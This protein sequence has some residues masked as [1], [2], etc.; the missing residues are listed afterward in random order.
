MN[1]ANILHERIAAG[2]VSI[3]VRKSRGWSPWHQHGLCQRD[4]TIVTPRDKDAFLWV[5]KRCM[6]SQF[7]YELVGGGT[8]TSKPSGVDV[9][10]E[11]KCL[12]TLFIDEA[13]QELIVGAGVTVDSAEAF[14]A[15]RG[16]TLGQWLGSGATA[17]IGGSIVTNA[18]GILAGRYGTLRDAISSVEVVDAIGISTWASAADFRMMPSPTLLTVRI[19]LWLSPEGRALAR[20]VGAGDPFTA[21]RQVTTARLLPAHISVDQSG[22]ITVIAEGETHLETARYQ[23]IAAILQKHGAVQDLAL[24]QNRHWDTLISANPWSSNAGG[25]SWADRIFVQTTWEACA[26]VLDN[27]TQRAIR[28][29]AALTWNAVNPSHLGVW[30][31]IDINIPATTVEPEWLS[32]GN[33]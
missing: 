29:G 20:F 13:A 19:P 6:D 21:L 10:I 12:D 4:V 14:V 5:V 15:E 11:T 23:L 33:L 2:D 31:I 24:D 28:A 18:M 30:L 3:D 25:D 1:I 16:W 8:S 22:A 7:P 32:D 26:G 27:W 17:S 9:Q